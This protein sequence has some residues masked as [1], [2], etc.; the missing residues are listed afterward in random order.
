MSEVAG[1]KEH[2]RCGRR[3]DAPVVTPCG[4]CSSVVDKSRLI[5]APV[6][7]GKFVLPPWRDSLSIFCRLLVINMGRISILL[8]VISGMQM[9]HV[10]RLEQRPKGNYRRAYCHL[11]LDEGVTADPER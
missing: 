1:H 2:R 4:M 10:G 11:N 9:R 3:I 7:D 8:F 5:E 6:H